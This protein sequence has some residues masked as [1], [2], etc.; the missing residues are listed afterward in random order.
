[1]GGWVGLVCLYCGQFACCFILC[2]FSAH[3]TGEFGYVL[4]AGGGGAACGHVM[5]CA[6]HISWAQWVIGR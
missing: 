5:P 3:V 2:V 4:G 1:M 6:L